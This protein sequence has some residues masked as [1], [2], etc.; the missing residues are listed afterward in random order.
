MGENSND[1]KYLDLQGLESLFSKLKS[2]F[3][4]AEPNKVL[5]DYNFNEQ[6]KNKLEND[7]TIVK[8]TKAEYD[9]LLE[10]NNGVLEDDI[11]YFITD[12]DSL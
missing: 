11:V 1:K 8:L 2:Y 12:V 6:L 7:V 3:V 10:Q 4:K 9:A 5:S